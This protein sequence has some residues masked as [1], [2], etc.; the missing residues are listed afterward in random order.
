MTTPRVNTVRA[1]RSRER[2]VSFD[3]HERAVEDQ[4]RIRAEKVRWLEIEREKYGL[5]RRGRLID[6]MP[7]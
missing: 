2:K 4:R 3:V 7:V 5:P 1:L 6:D